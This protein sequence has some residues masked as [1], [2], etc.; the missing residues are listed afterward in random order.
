MRPHPT[1][2]IL[3]VDGAAAGAL[4]VFTWDGNGALTYHS[5]VTANGAG[6]QCW[7]AID[8]QA[9][10]LYASAIG[11]DVISV[12]SIADPLN[13]VFVQNFSLGGPRGTLPAGTPEPVAYT[14]APFNLSL[15][16][17]GQHLY[18]VNHTTCTSTSIDATNCPAGNAI[19][20]LNV[21]ADG[22]LT[23]PPTSPMIFPATMVPNETHP[24]GII[25]L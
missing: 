2:P 10:F 4:V 25:V 6:V 3:Y 9:K 18:V 15:D 7:T 17:S 5:A 16:P 21:S 19:H 8:P 12:F 22:T 24:K 1:Q 11:P 20:V 13:P 23:E 14:T